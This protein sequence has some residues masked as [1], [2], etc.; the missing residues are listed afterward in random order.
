MGLG[1][2]GLGFRQLQCLAVHY[3]EQQK[4]SHSRTLTANRTVLYIARSFGWQ[5]SLPEFPSELLEGRCWNELPLI[6]ANCFPPLLTMLGSHRLVRG[7]IEAASICLQ[8]HSK[9]Q[10][11]F[12]LRWAARPHRPEAVNPSTPLVPKKA[13]KPQIARRL[14]CTQP[15]SR[16]CRGSEE[17]QGFDHL[18]TPV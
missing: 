3:K 2:R 7:N 18:R 12:Q 6:Q 11:P 15:G 5:R 10:R 1:F 8:A 16:D 9:L 14:R 4:Q 13:R 17:S